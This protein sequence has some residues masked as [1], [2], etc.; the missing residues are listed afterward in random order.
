MRQMTPSSLSSTRGRT[1]CRFCGGAL[2]PFIDLGVSPPCE[3]FLTARQLNEGEH[4]SPLDVRVCSSCWLV[5]LG[6]FVSPEDIF[7]EYAYFSSYSQSWLAHARGYAEAM[8]E[9]FRLGSDSFV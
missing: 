4:F 2:H 1:N 6:E 8:I 3:S 7:T 5:Q 9:R